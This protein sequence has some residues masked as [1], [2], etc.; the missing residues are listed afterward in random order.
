MKIRAILVKTADAIIELLIRLRS[1]LSRGEQLV[2]STQAHNPSGAYAIGSLDWISVTPEDPALVERVQD[3]QA[4]VPPPEMCPVL[5]DGEQK[6]APA[7]T[8]DDRPEVY[9]PGTVVQIPVSPEDQALVEQV[10]KGRRPPTPPPM[11][12]E[13][14]DLVRPL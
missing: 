14:S 1:R 10:C 2:T 7:Q 5:P 11:I 8:P 4:S 3:R 13:L 12:Y 9:A 6:A